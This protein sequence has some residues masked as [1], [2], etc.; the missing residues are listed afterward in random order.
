MTSITI[1]N[2]SIENF[3]FQCDPH[4]TIHSIAF[5]AAISLITVIKIPKFMSALLQASS[6]PLKQQL[7]PHQQT[8][9]RKICGTCLSYAIMNPTGVESLILEF[10]Q[11][12]QQLD[13]F[14]NM[15]NGS[16][17]VLDARALQPV[18]KIVCTVPRIAE[19]QDAYFSN[20]GSQICA[21]IFAEKIGSTGGNS[22]D[23]SSLVYQAAMYLVTK[24]MNKVPRF[25]KKYII[26]VVLLPLCV[27]FYSVKSGRSAVDGYG[28]DVNIDLDGNL[29]IIDE[30]EAAQTFIPL[31]RFHELSYSSIVMAKSLSIKEM[32]KSLLQMNSTSKNQL[33]LTEL[34]TYRGTNISGMTPV[35]KLGGSGGIM[36]VSTPNT[37]FS[38][39]QDPE[40][41][42][43]FL[44]Y[45]D[46]NDLISGVFLALLEEYIKSNSSFSN[47]DD[48]D[49][50]NLVSIRILMIL[51]E[52]FGANL[53]KGTRKIVELVKSIVVSMSVDSGCLLLCLTILKGIISNL[54]EDQIDIKEKFNFTPEF[55]MVLQTLEDHPEAG[56]Q[57]VTRDIR[58]LILVNSIQKNTSNEN[59]AQKLQRE[60]EL[61][62]A[63]SMLELSDELLPVRAYGI[64]QIRKM[65]LSRNEVARKNLYTILCAFLDM[66]QDTDSFIYLHA[67]SGLSALTDVY[68]P[69][70]LPEIISRYTNGANTLDYRVRIGEV[71]NKTIQRAGPVFPK[72]APE[73][74]P[75]IL[76]VLLDESKELRG[77]AISLL[78][79]V[80]ET[81]PGPLAPFVEQ[82]FGYIENS[83]IFER[84]NTAMRQGCVLV[85]LGVVRG[86]LKERGVLVQAFPKGILKRIYT[87][88][89]IVSA[90]DTDELTRYNAG[91][92]LDEMRGLIFQ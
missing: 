59:E 4:S 13:D 53:I 55:N 78:G 39:V 86:V 19:S 43:N 66:V 27:K 51:I 29:V 91:V 89:K 34:A 35:A 20:I 42:V 75:R 83:L 18:A 81:A 12:Q 92:A 40:A 28:R 88:L 33:L 10:I 72:L 15:S 54:G 5:A 3:N 67:V 69:D 26:D 82:I 60:S 31:Y 84:E 49:A 76:R 38:I 77:S 8:L 63:K 58:R 79:V 41:F 36:F 71:A 61:L 85:L 22:V 32:L 62:F 17:Q 9:F 16:L 30:R 50:G 56:I 65:V 23:E 21:L 74:L 57:T 14:K 64:D 2:I 48:I 24:L 73:I 25:A 90:G 7:Q 37:D 11:Q 6:R 45:L 80:A 1:P 52:K 44:V 70:C 68:A 46:N 87:R 47:E